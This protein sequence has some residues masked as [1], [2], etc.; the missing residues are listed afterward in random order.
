MI[1]LI[2]YLLAIY[3]SLLPSV[4][5]FSLLLLNHW[6]R[7]LL[8]SFGKYKT[9]SLLKKSRRPITR[10]GASVFMSPVKYLQPVPDVSGGRNWYSLSWATSQKVALFLLYGRFQD[11]GE[12]RVC[13][14]YAYKTSIEKCLHYMRVF[15]QS[16]QIEINWSISKRKVVRIRTMY[17]TPHRY[18]ISQ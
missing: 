3:L 14:A 17:P 12:M 13:S 15:T 6:S 16:M 10:H 7:N 1:S 8:F 9:L 5:R 11:Y 4:K 18:F 2:C